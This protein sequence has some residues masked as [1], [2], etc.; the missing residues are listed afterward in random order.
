LPDVPSRWNQLAVVAPAE[1]AADT[2]DD[3]VSENIFDVEDEWTEMEIIARGSN[4]RATRAE[5]WN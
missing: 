3:R 1:F 4:V 5:C 2:L